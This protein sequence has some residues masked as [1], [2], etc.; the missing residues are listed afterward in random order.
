MA[1][2]AETE[3]RHFMPELKLKRFGLTQ[4]VIVLVLIVMLV[5][6]Y[7]GVEWLDIR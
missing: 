3:E 7:A 4:A 1:V 2:V 5:A 6:V